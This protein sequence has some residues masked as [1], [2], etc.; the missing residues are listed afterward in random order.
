MNTRIGVSY[1]MFTRLDGLTKNVDNRPASTPAAITPCSCT[2]SQCSELNLE[3]EELADS[4]I[5]TLVILDLLRPREAM[6]DSDFFAIAARQLSEV[7]RSSGADRQ[8]QQRVDLPVRQPF[9]K[10]RYVGRVSDAGPYTTVVAS[11]GPASESLTW[12]K[13]REGWGR[14]GQRAAM[15]ICGSQTGPVG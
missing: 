10:S 4:Q 3:H 5:N 1:T 6:S 8:G 12:R 7:L 13:P 15:G 9:R 2:H 14:V 11:R